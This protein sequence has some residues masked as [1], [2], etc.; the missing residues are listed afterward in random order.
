MHTQR[1]VNV[2]NLSLEEF[3]KIQISY[4]ELNYTRLTENYN[5]EAW[6]RLKYIL[7]CFGFLCRSRHQNKYISTFKFTWNLDLLQKVFIILITYCSHPHTLSHTLPI[8]FYS[9]SLSLFNRKTD[10]LTFS[11]ARTFTKKGYQKRCMIYK[12]ASWLL[13][14]Q[15]GRKKSFH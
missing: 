10:S 5:F 12:R 9:L 8:T 13:Q 15:F 2:I 3:L 14:Q 7:H 11:L 1:W 6:S 4:F